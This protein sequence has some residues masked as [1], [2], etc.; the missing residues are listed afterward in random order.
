LSYLKEVAAIFLTIGVSLALGYWEE[1][2][3]GYISALLIVIFLIGA[4]IFFFQ[5]RYAKSGSM[6]VCALFVLG[7][8][9]KS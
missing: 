8:W 9:A 7:L 2:E 4:T 1:T 5:G 3:N 6:V